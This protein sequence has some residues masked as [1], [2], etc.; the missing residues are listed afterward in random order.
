[1]QM[2]VDAYFVL[3]AQARG[4]AIEKTLGIDATDEAFRMVDV[5]HAKSVHSAIAAA[6]A[7]ASSSDPALNDLIRQTQDTDQ[8]LVAL[9]DMLKATLEAPTAEQSADLLQSMRKDIAQ[10]QQARRTLLAEIERRFPQYA[11]LINPK[12]VGIAQARAKLS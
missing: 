11:Q 6:S 8:Q 9:S 2:I 12:P 3:L 10:L 1:R 5:A 7:R 4:T